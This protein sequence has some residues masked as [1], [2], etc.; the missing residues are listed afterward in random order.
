MVNRLSN[1]I[2]EITKYGL[3]S[4]YSNKKHLYNLQK[5]LIELLHFYMD[6]EFLCDDIEYPDFERNNYSYI[7][8]NLKINFPYLGSYKCFANILDLTNTQDIIIQNTF[9]DLNDIILD[10]LEVKYRLEN[11]G[12]YAGTDT[13]DFLFNIGMKQ[14]IINVICYIYQLK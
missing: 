12:E 1:L 8:D 5:K 14:K 2:E 9:T 6:N 13:F 3:N 11:N 10:L 4:N 7:I